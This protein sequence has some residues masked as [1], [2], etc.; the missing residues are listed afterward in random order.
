MKNRINLNSLRYLLLIL[1][2]FFFGCNQDNIL[3]EIPRDFLTTS[4]AYTTVSGI[5]QAVIGLYSQARYWQSPANLH[6]GTDVSYDGES[7]GANRWLT[8]YPLSCTPQGGGIQ[9]QVE[10]FWSNIFRLI[11][12]CNTVIAEIDK[13]DQ[14][15]WTGKETLKARYIAEAQFFRAFVYYK[16]VILYGDIPVLT[17]PTTTAKVDFT[18]DPKSEVF[19]LIEEDLLYCTVNLP[20][21]GTESAEGRLTKGAAWHQMI[22]VYLAQGKFQPAVD[23]ATHVINDF[24]YQMMTD[25]F[26]NRFEP[27]GSG[28]VYWDLFRYGNQ[29]PSINKETI[30]TFQNEPLLAQGGGGPT[31]NNW[32][33]RYFSWGKTPDGFNS[34]VKEFNDTLGRP[35]AYNRGTDLVFFTVW[36]DNWYNDIRNA[37][38]NIKRHFYFDNPASAY[39]G[40]EISWKLYPAGTRN[41]QKDTL[42]YIYPFFMK[43]WQPVIQGQLYPARAGNAE[44][45]ADQYAMRLAETFLL[46]AEAYLGLGNKTAAAD[47]INVVRNRANATPVLPDNVDIDYILDER[48]REL[49]MEEERLIVLMRMGKLIDRVRRYCDN[50]LTPA[51]NIQDHNTVLPIPQ[52]QIDLNRAVQW[53]Q[54]P[55]Y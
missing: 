21:P 8:N 15:I 41:I 9:N 53:Q 55:G 54:N 2:F 48:V 22:S 50:P 32:N 25:R 12:M 24:G 30:W 20:A 7:P 36:K 18:R 5:D 3:E 14:T 27:L 42:N 28:D 44:N 35:V 37:K 10:G 52:S 47:D 34:F 33:C 11:H 16:G 43:G 51:A 46:R 6:R 40:Q 26:G 4:N 39:H 19:K 45:H 49:Y 13:S 23:A 17:E 38:H 29:K 31:T 1:P